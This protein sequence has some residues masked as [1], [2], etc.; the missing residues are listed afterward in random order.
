MMNFKKMT[1]FFSL[2][3]LIVSGISAQSTTDVKG[4]RDYPLV[5]RF[6]GAII[7][8]YKEFKWDDYQ[9]PLS[10]MVK[11][12]D[13]GRFFEKQINVEGKVTR[14]QYIVSADNNTAFVY[15]NYEAAFKSAGFK[16]LFQGKGD[17]GLGEESE[18]FCSTFYGSM[19]GKF[20]YAFNPRGE[21]HAMIVAE[22]KKEGKDIYVVEYISGFSDATLITQDVIEAESADTGL[23]SA[24][25]LN[26][27]ITDTGHIAVYDIHFDGNKALLKTDSEAALKT[28]A[29]Y[30]K[31][32]GS[33]H[34]FIVGHAAG[35]G[36]FDAG[37]KLSGERAEAVR[38]ALIEQYGVDANQISAY[39][40]G[41]LCPLASNSTDA[42]RAKNRRVEIVVR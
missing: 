32:H 25:A 10:K 3:S 26:E 38:K 2:F 42:G 15:K 12:D 19:T 27:A 33:M 13:R 21:D 22:T 17:D 31:S 28:I 34:F 41:A 9:V 16:I 11:N 6:Q 5:S 35:I 24:T 40:V 14:W 7:Q 29:D 18:D 39:G 30:L 8:Y 37:F 23:V 20:G 36:D 1:A 4:S